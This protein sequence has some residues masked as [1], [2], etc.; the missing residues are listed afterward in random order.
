MEL[1]GTQVAQ[2]QRMRERSLPSS[3]SL[4]MAPAQA[5][6]AK[7]AAEPERKANEQDDGLDKYDIS[8]LH[9]TD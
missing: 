2:A 5:E 9:C 4:I 3:P 7:P 8:T 1:T 6:A